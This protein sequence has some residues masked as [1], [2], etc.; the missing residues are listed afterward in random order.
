MTQKWEA[1]EWLAI[2]R[3][4]LDELAAQAADG[5]LKA[6]RLTRSIKNWDAQGRCINCKAALP[7]PAAFVLV[8]Q[9]DGQKIWAAGICARC[10][11]SE[12]KITELAHAHVRRAY[13]SMRTVTPG[14]A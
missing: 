4:Q 13:P 14:T 5:N 2:A 12:S 3:Y 6:Q 10:G 7:Q 1:M 8:L 11:T 9:D